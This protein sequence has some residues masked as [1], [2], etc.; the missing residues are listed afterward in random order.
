MSCHLSEGKKRVIQSFEDQVEVL[1]T[2]LPNYLY[3]YN[4][5][6]QAQDYVGRNWLY[7]QLIH[8]PTNPPQ[9][10]KFKKKSKLTPHD[11]I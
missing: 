3:R 9:H 10:T 2:P 5:Q 6:A 11:Y 8:P 7:C 1:L 4:Y